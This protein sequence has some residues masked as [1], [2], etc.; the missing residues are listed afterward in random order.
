M[1]EAR[2]FRSI[3]EVE[4]VEALTGNENL[5]LNDGGKMKQIKASNAKVGSGGGVTVFQFV[6]DGGA[7]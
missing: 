5:L 4:E 2:E 6:V 3:T 7:K 1:A